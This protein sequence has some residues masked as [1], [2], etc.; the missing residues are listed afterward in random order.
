MLPSGKGFKTRLVPRKNGG[1]DGLQK[2]RGLMCL[3]FGPPV[4]VRAT[5]GSHAMVS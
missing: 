4:E 5:P 1:N 2:R 3:W